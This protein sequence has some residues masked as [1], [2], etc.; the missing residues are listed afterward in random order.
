M[1]VI[2]V[3]KVLDKKRITGKRRV[4]EER[5]HKGSLTPQTSTQ[6]NPFAL[7]M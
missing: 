3:N 1:P 6:K 4:K 2:P 5:R 7:H